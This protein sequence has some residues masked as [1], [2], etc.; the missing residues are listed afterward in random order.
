[1]R[2]YGSALRLEG[3]D[4]GTR[5]RDLQTQG[6][7]FRQRPGETNPAKEVEQVGERKVRDLSDWPA[8]E[9][10]HATESRGKVFVSV[11]L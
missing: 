4:R 5:Q 1:M 11:A 8:S 7:G 3:V 2:R 9:K 10:C 6:R